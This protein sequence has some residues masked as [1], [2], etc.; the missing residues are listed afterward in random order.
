MLKYNSDIVTGKFTRFIFVI[1]NITGLLFT[2][3]II[4]GLA[5]EGWHIWHERKFDDLANQTLALI[6][7]FF[8]V[9]LPILITTSIFS[10][11]KN[12]L[13]TNYQ[14]SLIEDTRERALN[15]IQSSIELGMTKYNFF[16]IL[17]STGFIAMLRSISVIGEEVGLNKIVLFG[18]VLII[19]LGLLF[20]ILKLKHSIVEDSFKLNAEK[21][22]LKFHQSKERSEQYLKDIK[23]LSLDK[24]EELENTVDEIEKLTTNLQELEG[25]I[26]SKKMEIKQLDDLISDKQDKQ[27]KPS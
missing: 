6:E 23:Q 24:Q 26:V 21:D 3:A 19:I 17:I 16:A 25:T 8:F 2:L 27:V 22:S 18:F 20:Y 10:Y 13:S 9:P 7:L 12:V 1:I 14:E 5:Y 11:Y 15:Y 4:I